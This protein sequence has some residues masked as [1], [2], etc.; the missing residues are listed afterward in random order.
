MTPGVSMTLPQLARAQCTVDGLTVRLRRMD[1][2][3][4]AVLLV[5]GPTRCVDE[6]TLIGALWP[7][8]DRE[9][10]NARAVL[11]QYVAHLRGAG[12][13]I[14]C[15]YARGWRIPERARAGAQRDPWSSRRLAA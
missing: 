7:D 9:P 10:G 2:E 3:L 15:E 13:E 5:S 6:A 11:Y 14:I 8:P 4:L 12:I 1:A